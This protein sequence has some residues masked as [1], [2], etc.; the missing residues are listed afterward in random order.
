MQAVADS[1]SVKTTEKKG[2]ADTRAAR[3]LKAGKGT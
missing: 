2:S 3:K 1:Q